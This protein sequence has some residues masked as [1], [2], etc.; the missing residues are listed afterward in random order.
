ML[1]TPTPSQVLTWPPSQVDLRSWTRLDWSK[2]SPTSTNVSP[3]S[4]VPKR[5]MK[6]G[7]ASEITWLRRLGLLVLLRPDAVRS[8]AL[9]YWVQRWRSTG[10]GFRNHCRPRSK[11]K[12]E[13]EVVN[14]PNLRRRRGR[15][16]ARQ[17]LLPRPVRQLQRLRDLGKPGGRV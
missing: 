15:G 3:R 17:S 10:S 11:P 4:T 1:P 12:L 13:E 2:S 8:L 9:A 14:P 16:R 5:T 6:M 7:T